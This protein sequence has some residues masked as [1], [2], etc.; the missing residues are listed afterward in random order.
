MEVMFGFFATSYYK[1]GLEM[2]R[3]RE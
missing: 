1:A 2:N 3:C